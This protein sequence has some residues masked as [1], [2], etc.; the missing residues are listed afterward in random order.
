LKDYYKIL[1]IKFNS[2][3][4]EIKKAYR[5][6]ALFWHPD[7]NSSPNA[8][9]KFIEITEAYN[10]LINTEKRTVYNKLYESY[11]KI[12]SNIQ[13]FSEQDSNYIKYEQWAKEERINAEKLSHLSMDNILTESFHFIDKYGWLLVIGILLLSWLIIA[14]IFKK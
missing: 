10:I 3:N 12:K 5:L 7:K 1:D 2:S 8:Q 9:D 11:F 4:E 6:A 14:I 13:P